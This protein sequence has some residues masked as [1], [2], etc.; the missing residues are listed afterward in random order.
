MP[1]ANADVRKS[2]IRV[3]IVDDHPVVRTG[4]RGML[5]EETRFEV[6]GE[7]EDGLRALIAVRDLKPDVALMDLR[8][9]RMDGVAA[10]EAIILRHPAT[11]VL[12]LTTYD[13][14]S[15]ILRAIEAGATGYLLKDAPR[16][17]LFRAIESTAEGASWLTPQV[18]S[19]VMTRIRGPSEETLSGRERDVLGH[20]AKG[21]TNKE[22]AAALSISEATV[23]THLIHIYRK[24]NV[25]SRTA[26]LAAAIERGLI[27]ISP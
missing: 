2:P 26:A 13:S 24:L 27:T 17:E 23:K 22:I 20:V 9:P 12:V 11:R 18:A 1:E 16:D 19:R 15:D 6:V 8:M 10:I 7:A 14:D 21:S 25:E 5:A 4:L 3:L